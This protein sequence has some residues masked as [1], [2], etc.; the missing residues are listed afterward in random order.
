MRSAVYIFALILF[1]CIL[2][3]HQTYSKE[4]KVKGENLRVFDKEK[5]YIINGDVRAE[6]DDFILF[7]DTLEIYDKEDIKV[8]E[9]DFTILNASML[10]NC[11][12]VEI[13]KKIKVKKFLNLDGVVL[14]L[15]INPHDYIDY[16]KSIIDN[17]HI[18][19]MKLKTSYIKQIEEN[20]FYA[21]DIM[22]TLCNCKEDNT[23]ELSAK[24]LYY[25][26]D[27]FLLSLSNV[28]YFYGLPSFYL[29][30][31]ILPVGERRS[32]F[33]LP[34]IG[35][36][37]IMGYSLKNAYYQT[38]GTSADATIYLNL[39]SRKGEMYSIEFR[40]KPLHNLYGKMMF[41]FVNDTSDSPFDKRFNIKN[42]H[43]FEYNERVNIG[44]TTHLVSDSSYMYDFLFDFW[45]RNTEYTLSR[46]YLNF[47]KDSFLFNLSNDFYQN[48]KQNLRPEKF[49]LFSDIGLAESQRFPYISVSLLPQHL[50]LNSDLMIETTYVNYYSLSYDYKKFSYLGNPLIT[51][52]EERRLFTFQRF[53]FG[54]P[55]H[56]Y[57]DIGNFL[58]IDHHLNP[59]FRRYQLPNTSYN[60]TTLNY[61]LNIDCKL[62][63]DFPP[64]IHLISPSI[65]YKNL[66]YLK[67]TKD[68]KVY[69]GRTVIK[70]EVD[71]YIKSQYILFHLS[72]F[73]YKKH[74]TKE[75]LDFDISQGYQDI[76]REGFTPFIISTSVS[77]DYIKLGN[78][79]FYYWR[80]SEPYLDTI[81]DISINDKRGDSLNL[82]YQKINNYLQNPLVVF[83]EEFEY[84]LPSYY[85]MGLNDIFGSINLRIFRE[86]SSSYFITYSF[87]QE[88]LVFHGLGIYYHSRCN[89]LNAGI[90]FIMYDWYEFP[91]FMTNLNLGGNL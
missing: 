38:L 4:V 54:L 79:L 45:E 26:K 59:T 24:S 39:M 53:S 75:L 41:S 50:Y 52:D 21:K 60:L 33:L 18:I 74:P 49:N 76:T 86:I 77:V 70:D 78:N 47:W 87:E 88:K 64:L 62:Y 11:K 90:S 17:L 10:L 27:G 28:I 7:A 5:R 89:C 8:L 22:Y 44:I 66:F 67:Y 73:L 6:G 71:N 14:K 72:N 37:S 19:R 30:I 46:F 23:W 42:E 34:E 81:V 15:P 12:K 40:Y 16:E 57:F 91:S 56:Q 29:P 36:N 13:F 63:R 69:Y 1:L 61:G 51:K 68:N 9:G 43:K 84:L 80:E 65:E 58:N 35:F 20:R 48:F 31:I 83:N 2:L 32:G 3:P 55:I 25:E 82:K 85:K